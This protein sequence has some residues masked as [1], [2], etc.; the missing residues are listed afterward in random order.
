MGAAMTGIGGSI[1]RVTD[2]DRLKG[3]RGWLLLP[4]VIIGLTSVTLLFLLVSDSIWGGGV[5]TPQWIALFVYA[6]VVVGIG[7]FATLRLLQEKRSARPWMLTFFGIMLVLNL[8]VVAGSYVPG[9]PFGLLAA[10]RSI[11]FPTA[12]IVY[13]LVSRRVKLTLVNGR[14]QKR[15]IDR[16]FA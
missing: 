6:F 2:E 8:L 13:F 11:G 3:V 10:V 14:G 4:P 9:E 15:N 16:S 12:M 1:E 7:G 5:G